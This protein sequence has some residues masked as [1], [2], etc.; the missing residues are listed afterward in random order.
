MTSIEFGH[1]FA[2]QRIGPD[3]IKSQQQVPAP[4]HDTT[5]VVLVDDYSAP[6]PWDAREVA[7][8]FEDTGHGPDLIFSLA[9]IAEVTDQFVKGLSQQT[10]EQIAHWSLGSTRIPTPLLIATWNAVRTNLIDGPVDRLRGN[11]HPRTDH[12]VSALPVTCEW[13]EQEAAKLLFEFAEGTSR[14]ISNVTW[15]FEPVDPWAAFNPEAYSTENYEVI[16]EV[17]RSLAGLLVDAWKRR[18]K[19]E[20]TLEVGTGANLYPALAASEHSARLLL[21]DLN[22][23]N[24]DWI[25][26]QQLHLD[27]H[28]IEFGSTSLPYREAASRLAMAEVRQLSLHHLSTLVHRYPVIQM[29]FV[30]DSM[31]SDLQEVRDCL[32]QLHDALTPDGTLFGVFTLGSRGYCVARSAFP[33][34]KLTE[35]ALRR[36]LRGVGFQQVQITEAEGDKFRAGYDSVVFV[37]ASR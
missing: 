5:L 23:A 1:H 36:E 25:R 14:S 3:Q 33:A 8:Q 26:E 10:V 2:G 31:T 13:V 4:A 7:E 6:K 16:Q 18:G 22:T 9:D 34:T 30:V 37:E 12:L 17:D 19:V 21:T 27:P 35:D 29:F 32:A 20:R 15:W 28:W 11:H 24:L